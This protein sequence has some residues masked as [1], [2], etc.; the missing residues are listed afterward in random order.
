MADTTTQHTLHQQVLQSLQEA[1]LEEGEVIS[2]A[3]Q[4]VWR[5][6]RLADDAPLTVRVGLAGSVPLFNELPK[7][8]NASESEIEA[9]L[10]EGDFRVEWV[11]RSLG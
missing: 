9:A 7:L 4:L 2:L 3:S 6:G 11:G 10:S 8:R 5:I 1:G